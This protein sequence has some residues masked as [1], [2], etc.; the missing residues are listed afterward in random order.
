VG[1]GS[2]L[3]TK[4]IINNKDFKKLTEN[5]KKIINMIREIKGF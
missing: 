2:N 5:T 4:E 3:I 1:I